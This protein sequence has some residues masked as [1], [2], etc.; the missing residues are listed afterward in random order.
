MTDLAAFPAGAG[1]DEAVTGIQPGH[2]DARV[3]TRVL[4]AA[5]IT[6]TTVQES[7]Q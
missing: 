5:A 6:A 2:R 3:A 1:V 4:P 7:P